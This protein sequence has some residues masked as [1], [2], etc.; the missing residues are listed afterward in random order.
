MNGEKK[1]FVKITCKCTQKCE[2]D[3][4][5]LCFFFCIHNDGHTGWRD[6]LYSPM[7]YV[8]VCVS[9]NEPKKK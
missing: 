3:T 1:N 9:Y 5:V 8:Y 4:Q 7:N 6:P 2:V